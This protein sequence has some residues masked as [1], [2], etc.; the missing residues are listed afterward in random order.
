M[1]PTSAF[2][3]SAS[4][5]CVSVLFG[6]VC[7]LSL[8]ILPYMSED[9]HR[10]EQAA[11]QAVCT[12]L[13]HFFMGGD[14]HSL[15]VVCLRA[16]HAES[17]LEGADSPH[18]ES[19]CHYVC[20]TFGG[21]S[22][23]GAFTSIPCGASS[24]FAEADQQLC[25]WELQTKPHQ[26]QKNGTRRSACLPPSMD[27]ADGLETGSPYLHLHSSD[28]ALSLGSEACAAVFPLWVT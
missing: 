4:A 24:A 17:A 20:F 18:Y 5:L 2:W 10:R 9:K 23:E 27:L 1:E 25:S 15:C 14:T 6:V 26:F 11:S 16:K 12:S 13:S 19:I 8:F 3:H 7:P 22:W 21:F 28:L